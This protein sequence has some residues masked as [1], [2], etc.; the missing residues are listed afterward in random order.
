[1]L[2]VMN[3]LILKPVSDFVSKLQW[4]ELTIAFL[5]FAV[6]FLILKTLKRKLAARFLDSAYQTKIDVRQIIYELSGATTSLTI[7]IVAV[8]F[9]LAAIQRTGNIAGHVILI[10]LIL[11]AAVWVGI[12]IKRLLD[13]AYE[14]KAR[15][16][17][18]GATAMGLVSF[19]A[20]FCVW[21]VAFLLILDNLG[22]NITALVAGL[23]IGGVA[24]ALAVQNILGDLMASLSI[25]FDKP[26]VVGDSIIVGEFTGTVEA[27]GIKT[28][29][30]R[31]LQGEQ[32]IFSNSD[33]L[34]SRIRNYKRL[35]ERRVLFT[36]GVTYQTGNDV[37]SKIPLMLEQIVKSQDKVR[38]DRA[39]FKNF[40]DSALIFEVVYFVI[41]SEFNVYMDIQQAI[42]LEIFRQFNE[43]K[44]EFAYPTS[45]VYLPDLEDAAGK[46]FFKEKTVNG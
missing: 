8:W 31:S 24:I 20:R 14:E 21:I 2:T 12:V 23:G 9:A 28:T 40:G 3:E 32:V 26:F 4:E 41:S 42:N 18:A 39:H 19:V 37:L 46:V 36:I 35:Y 10:T 15:N 27:I 33:L 16:D 43:Q 17:P 38:F 1:M 25:V 30:L 34:S 11:Q 13:K 22:V 6:S 7:L 44:I 45:T 29:R 5:V